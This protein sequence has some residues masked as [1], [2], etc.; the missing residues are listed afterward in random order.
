M[1]RVVVD[2]YAG[3]GVAQAVRRIGGLDL[4]VEIE[5]A[6]I[7]IREVNGFETIYEDV[8]DI[9]LLEPFVAPL[10]GWW[11]K[12]GS[13]P[14]QLWSNAGKGA[15]RQHRATLIAAM[16]DGIYED[17]DALRAFGASLGDENFAHVLV[18]LTYVHR[19]RPMFVALEQVPAVLPLWQEMVPELEKMGY[20]AK[21]AYLHSEQHGVPQTRKRAFLV[22]RRDGVEVQLPAP[23]HSKYHSRTPEKMDPDVEPWVSMAEGLGWQEPMLYAGAGRTAVDTS[24]QRQR[25]VAEPAHTVTGGGSAVRVWPNSRPA[26]T[27]TGGGRAPEGQSP[28]DPA[29]GERSR[30]LLMRSNY[31][32]GGEP[33]NRGERTI[34]EPAPTITSKIDRNKWEETR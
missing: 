11:T 8:W 31:G 34:G 30:G 2:L 10:G 29:A 25:P 14:C 32:S 4:G 27:V 22:A 16:H 33:A 28:S 12:W 9:D 24:G 19:Y 5:P 26:P 6:A 15:A 20:S 18:P 3:V 13:P 7:A 1:K 17:I 21:A 23:T